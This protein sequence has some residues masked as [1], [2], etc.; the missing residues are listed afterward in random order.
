MLRSGGIILKL[1]LMVSIIIIIE[2]CKLN[3]QFYF[4]FFKSNLSTYN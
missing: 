2:E 4:L 1:F 3:Y